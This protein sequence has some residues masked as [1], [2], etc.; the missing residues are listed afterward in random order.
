M[1]IECSGLSN[2]LDV[3]SALSAPALLR[4]VAVSHIICLV[5]AARVER[6]LAAVELARTQISG[7][8]VLILNKIDTV[9]KDVSAKAHALIDDFAPDT[10][11]YETSYGDIGRE[12]LLKLL[13]DPAPV[14][15]ACGCSHDDGHHNHHHH[16]H[17]LPASFCTVALNL[18]D[19]V[20]REA[21][22][23]L[24]ELLPE[25]VIRAKGFANIEQNGWHILQKTFDSFDI[26]PFG[27][28][29]PST[30]SI[31]VCIG[32]HLVADEIK[33]VLSD[34]VGNS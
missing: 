32:Q 25:N 2:P 5:D 9:D 7:S 27:S 16:S 21:L 30:G 34:T 22:G 28:K 13:N 23:K 10:K 26:T 11:V 14:Q 1:I 3:V 12:N 29:A 24:M 20:D 19:Q 8:D 4:E 6:A 17:S 31:L 18:P 15:C 33:R